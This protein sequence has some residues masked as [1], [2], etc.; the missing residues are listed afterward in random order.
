MFFWFITYDY[1]NVH[2]LLIF[3]DAGTSKAEPMDWQ[4]DT[5][6]HF[7]SSRNNFINVCL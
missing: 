3:T 4:P 1:L 5:S 2:K 6:C 7:C